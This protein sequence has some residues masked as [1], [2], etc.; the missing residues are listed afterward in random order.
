[1]MKGKVWSYIKD[2]KYPNELYNKSMYS[3]MYDMKYIEGNDLCLHKNESSVRT[4]KN[5][6]IRDVENVDSYMG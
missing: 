2:G 6:E 5:D 4:N 3:I 1:M